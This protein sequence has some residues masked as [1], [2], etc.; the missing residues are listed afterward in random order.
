MLRTARLS[1]KITPYTRPLIFFSC[2]HQ[3][4]IHRI[5]QY[6]SHAIPHIRDIA[7][8]L[9]CHYHPFH[10]TVRS[11]TPCIILGIVLFEH[12]H[13]TL[14]SISIFCSYQNMQMIRHETICKNIYIGDPR[15]NCKNIY[16][17]LIVGVI[18]EQQLA[19][20]SFGTDMIEM[21]FIGSVT[22][23]FIKTRS[24]HNSHLLELTAK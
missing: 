22:R 13:K 23:I 10:N 7:H 5:T 20:K 17:F 14:G 6:I 24:L 1:R 18:M 21:N 9:D 11:V 8:F 16:S 3:A 19:F 2:L 4:S 12:Y 15:H